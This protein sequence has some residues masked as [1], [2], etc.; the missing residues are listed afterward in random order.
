MVGQIIRE[1]LGLYRRLFRS[2]VVAS[3]LIFLP[4]T[5]AMLALQLAVPD[6]T[7]TQQSLAIIDAVGSVLLFAPLASI[8]IIRCAIAA[9]QTGSARARKE[10]G[11][12]FA[13]LV[14]YVVTQLLVLLVIV[15]LPGLL[16]A[17]GYATGSPTIMT[18]GV[19][20]LL[21]SALLNG[22]RLTVA[23]V[24]V[25]TGDAR[26]ALALR[27]SAGLTRGNWLRTL[28]V[29]V[30]LTLIALVIALTVSSVGLAFP[31]GRAQDVGTSIFGLIGNAL[32]VPIVAL[33]SYRLYR[34]LEAQAS[35]RRAA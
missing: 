27:R 21:A 4:L 33:G 10:V 13:L 12:A 28:G 14:P 5:I 29:L 17:A 24:A 16:I 18:M 35:A 3:F 11:P 30:A 8:V 6:T 26:N 15:A 31:S 20:V 2:L 22:V 9:E 34:V 7:R 25:V 1:A 32:T 23:T 19:G